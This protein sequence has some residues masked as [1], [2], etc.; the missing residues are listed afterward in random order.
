V[1]PRRDFARVRDAVR[2]AGTVLVAAHD[3]FHAEARLVYV[4]VA[5][6][7][8]LAFLARIQRSG[9]PAPHLVPAPREECVLAPG[10]DAEGDDPWPATSR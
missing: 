3:D 10:H 9:V 6:H 8:A 7:E 2:S 5:K 1:S 4:R